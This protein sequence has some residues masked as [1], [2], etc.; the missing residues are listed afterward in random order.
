M[1]HEE[2]TKR[3]VCCL[4]QGVLDVQESKEGELIAHENVV[5]KHTNGLDINGNHEINC[6]VRIMTGDGLG[7]MANTWVIQQEFWELWDEL[8]TFCW[9]AD[10]PTF[11][12]M[13]GKIDGVDV[14]VNLWS[15]NPPP[16]KATA[17]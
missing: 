8:P 5:L 15:R 2:L 7:P 1:A 13:C 6:R 16:S 11:I 10:K 3:V 17:P 14:T 4:R 9:V 12:Q